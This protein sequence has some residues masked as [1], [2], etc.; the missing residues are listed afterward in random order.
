MEV[1]LPCKLNKTMQ[2]FQ[3]LHDTIALIYQ[4]D[5]LSKKENSQKEIVV[6]ED[7][8]RMVLHIYQ[9]VLVSNTA[10]PKKK[11]SKFAYICTLCNMI[12]LIRY[13]VLEVPL[14]KIV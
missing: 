14:I 13:F 12:L 1:L 4:T 6:L 7:S 3:M 8:I 11:K 2:T 5:C 10:A 9:F